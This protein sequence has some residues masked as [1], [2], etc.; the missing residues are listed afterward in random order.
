MHLLKVSLKLS[1]CILNGFDDT[2][3]SLLAQSLL[4]SRQVLAPSIEKTHIVRYLFEL[5]P[6]APIKFFAFLGGRLFE[7]GAN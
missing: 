3:D 1:T 7:V 5:A 2:T 4:R 6:W